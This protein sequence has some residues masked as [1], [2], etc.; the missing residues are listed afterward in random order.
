M[1]SRRCRQRARN[2][3]PTRRC[4]ST[5]SSRQPLV[6]GPVSRFTQSARSAAVRIGPSG[7]RGTPGRRESPGLRAEHDVLDE[8]GARRIAPADEHGERGRHLDRR[9]IVPEHIVVETGDEPQIVIAGVLVV[10]RR[11]EQLNLERCRISPGSGQ[12][13]GIRLELGGRR[14]ATDACRAVRSALRRAATRSAS[15][16]TDDERRRGWQWCGSGSRWRGWVRS[17]GRRPGG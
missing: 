17:W 2:T 13:C 7:A 15:A 16:A 10:L 9:W 6:P 3:W 1:K 5:M 14:A 8:L 12:L 4:Y 11:G